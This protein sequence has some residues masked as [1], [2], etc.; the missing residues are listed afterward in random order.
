MSKKP[1]EGEHI[2]AII[3]T[4]GGSLMGNKNQN[5]AAENIREIKEIKRELKLT[6]MDILDEMK[7]LDPSHP[8]ALSTLRRVYAEHSEKKASGFNYDE[9]LMPIYKAVKSLEKKGKPEEEDPFETELRGYQATI[10][11]QNEELDRLY[12]MTDFLEGRVEFLVKE[13]EFLKGQIA[14]KDRRMDE[15]DAWINKLMNKI[16]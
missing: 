7:L 4:T 3:E 5:I 6:Y 14:V 2:A 10:V 12:E 1:S 11:C 16:L 13:I 15:K 8:G 9:T